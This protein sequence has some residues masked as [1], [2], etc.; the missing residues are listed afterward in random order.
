MDTKEK[1][2]R[3]VNDSRYFLDNL[4]SLLF[5]KDQE[6]NFVGCTENFSNLVNIHKDDLIGQSDHNLPWESCASLYR[7]YDEEALMGQISSVFE[8]FPID[9][10]T[11]LTIKTEKRPIHTNTGEIIGVLA[12]ANVLPINSSLGEGI[13]ALRIK[14]RKI[15]AQSQYEPR[16]YKITHFNETLKLTQRETECLFLLIRAKS[17]KEIA[18]FL[19]IS[20]RTV[21]SYIEQIK[22]KMGVSTRSEII[23]KAIE[24]RMLEIIPNDDILINLYKNIHKFKD[25]LA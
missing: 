16:N 8:P 14:D 9:R 4:S 7:E 24:M 6:S 17:A 23:T 15:T 10:N 20:I 25:F 18:L 11:I 3:F 19:E 5:I 21:E 1:L 22:N 2:D 12:Q 13:S